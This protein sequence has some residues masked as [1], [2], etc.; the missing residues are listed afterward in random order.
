MTNIY[1]NTFAGEPVPLNKMHAVITPEFLKSGRN[2]RIGVLVNPLSGGNRN[3][4]G[5]VRNT[6]ADY[7]QVLQS[8][9]QTPQEVLNAL[10]HFSSKEVDVVAVNGGD[11]TVQA[12]LTALFRHQPFKTLPLLVNLQ[13][14]LY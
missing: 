2:P 5:A 11:G 14:C 6:I 4:L 8:D 3:G 1:V 13:P 7:P 12:V 9:V 10:L